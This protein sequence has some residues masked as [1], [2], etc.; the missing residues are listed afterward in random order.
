MVRAVMEVVNEATSGGVTAKLTQS[1]PADI[2]DLV[3]AGTGS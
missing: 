1:L 2:S 3:M